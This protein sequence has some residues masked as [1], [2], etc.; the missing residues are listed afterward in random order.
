MNKNAITVQAKGLYS[1]SIGNFT[2]VDVVMLLRSDNRYRYAESF[3]K[4][5]EL[6]GI[7]YAFKTDPVLCIIKAKLSPLFNGK[8]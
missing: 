6:L 7:I 2:S 3:S 1:V 5:Q 8:N 4:V